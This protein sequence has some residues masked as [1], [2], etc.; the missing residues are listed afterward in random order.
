MLSFALLCVLCVLWA[1]SQSSTRYAYSEEVGEDF[2]EEEA[3]AL[4]T[5]TSVVDVDV[6]QE[7]KERKAVNTDVFSLDEDTEED[8][9]E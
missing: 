4:T 2:D 5:S 8:K 9:R 6:K 7:M 1:P 3:L